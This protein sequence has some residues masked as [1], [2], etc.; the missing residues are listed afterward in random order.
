MLQP[1]H[2]I[3]RPRFDQGFDRRLVDDPKIDPFA[4]IEDRRERAVGLPLGNDRAD[5]RG[6]GA[7]NGIEAET[8]VA[9]IIMGPD[10]VLRAGTV[11]LRKAES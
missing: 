2:R 5:R 10:G 8:D 4:E 1:V 7:P 6:A 3:E 11:T 9:P